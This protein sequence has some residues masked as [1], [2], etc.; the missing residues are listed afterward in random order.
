MAPV[1]FQISNTHAGF[2]RCE[3][4]ASLDDGKLVFEIQ[5]KVVGIVKCEIKQL[6][7]PLGEV[8]KIDYKRG[9]FSPSIRVQFKSLH[10]T[11]E[12]PKAEGNEVILEI[13]RRDRKAA[14]QLV[15]EAKLGMIEHSLD[16][17]LE[18]TDKALS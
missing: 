6:D 10:Q 14:E 1:P 4:M 5:S 17:M 3:G 16:D 15:E 12:F 8:A 11:Q 9:W 13:K 2:G 7:I 18:M